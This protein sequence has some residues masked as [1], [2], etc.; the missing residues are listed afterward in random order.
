MDRSVLE[1]YLAMVERHVA[2]SERHIARQRELVSKLM[3]DGDHDM[4]P[5]AQQ[6]LALL[7][8]MQTLHVADR[9]RLRAELTRS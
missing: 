3:R 5:G 1:Q 8:D 9:D 6:F 4:I 2:E 7:E